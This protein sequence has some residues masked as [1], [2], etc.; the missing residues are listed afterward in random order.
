MR[1]ERDRASIWQTSLSVQD[2]RELAVR[3]R[4]SCLRVNPPPRGSGVQVLSLRFSFRDHLSFV[5][6]RKYRTRC[7][8]QFARH[9]SL[10]MSPFQ[11]VFEPSKYPSASRE[12]SVRSKKTSVR[13]KKKKQK[14]LKKKV[15][16][17]RREGA[18]SKEEESSK[19]P[20]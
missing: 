3:A 16:G 8:C 17:G 6:R 13:S 4:R 12:T 9:I 2:A 1:T 5:G 11:L 15:K 19:E 14:N 7:D 20:V 18:S 10:H